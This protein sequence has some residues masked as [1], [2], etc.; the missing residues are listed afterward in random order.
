MRTVEHSYSLR[1]AAIHCLR[2]N[3]ISLIGESRAI[4]REER[5]AGSCYRNMLHE[6]R[7]GVVRDELRATH[8]ALAYLRG[9]QYC[10]VERSVSRPCPMKRVSEKLSKVMG[11]VSK[12][13]MYRGL[14][15][16]E[17]ISE[18]NSIKT[19]VEDVAVWST[20]E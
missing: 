17:A 9:R 11:T 13:R 1:V 19:S 2:V 5:R 15:G 20:R 3:L 6:H 4:R 7:V 10:Q 8:L 18:F 16:T 12:D 14:W